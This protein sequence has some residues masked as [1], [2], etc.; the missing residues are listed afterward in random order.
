MQGEKI[1]IVRYLERVVSDTLIQWRRTKSVPHTPESMP[2]TLGDPKLQDS[3]YGI[4]MCS[5]N[6]RKSTAALVAVLN[7]IGLILAASPATFP[8]L[9]STSDWT[10]ESILRMHRLYDVSRS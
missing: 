7:G 5:S 10:W 8:F 6:R 9:M 3:S 1:V 2:L 4:A